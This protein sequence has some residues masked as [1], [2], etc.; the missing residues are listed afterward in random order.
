VGCVNVAKRKV[1]SPQ[2]IF[3]SQRLAREKKTIL[4]VED[5]DFVRRV[6]CEVLRASGFRVLA[7]ANAQDAMGAFQ[8]HKGQVELVLTDLVMPGSNGRQLAKEL[9]EISPSLRII[10]TSG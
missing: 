6:T 2:A 1:S 3:S 8:K 9:K 4:L 5:E 7:A 10:L